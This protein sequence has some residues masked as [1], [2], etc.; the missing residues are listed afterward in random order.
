MENRTKSSSGGWRFDKFLG[1]LCLRGPSTAEVNR[2][3]RAMSIV[4]IG[5]VA[6]QIGAGVKVQ[7][8]R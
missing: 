7:R 3:P 2:I 6:L 5:R 8:M 1:L 4:G